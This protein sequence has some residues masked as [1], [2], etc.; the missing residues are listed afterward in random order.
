MTVEKNAYKP[1]VIDPVK[2]PHLA[3]WLSHGLGILLG[4]Y[5][6]PNETIIVMPDHTRTSLELRRVL[7]V[8][9]KVKEQEIAGKA[10]QNL[11]VG[12]IACMERTMR[13][14]IDGEDVWVGHAQGILGIMP[15]EQVE[16]NLHRR[17]EAK[18]AEA[19]GASPKTSNGER[20]V[21]A[22]ERHG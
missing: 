2:H 22:S 16:E 10:V 15:K 17:K 1:V 14:K 6:H 5:E 21:L 9:E 7:Y 20:P 12:D 11:K 13:L 4:A 8:G 19:N 18:A 3:A